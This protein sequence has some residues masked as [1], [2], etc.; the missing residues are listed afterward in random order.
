MAEKINWTGK[1]RDAILQEI[2][3]RG[4]DRFSTTRAIWYFCGDVLRLFPRTLRTYKALNALTVDMRQKQEIPWG[5]FSVVRG[6][7]G[8]SAGS[9]WSPSDFFNMYKRTFLN[10]KNRY[11][12]PKW[13][14]QDYHVEVWVEK[15]GLLPN[16]ERYIS[17]MDVQ[18]RALEGF[19]PWEFVHE[20]I[21][22]IKSYL[23]DRA[24]GAQIVIL[25]LGDNDPSG[26]DIDRQLQEVLDHFTLD[27]Q[28]ERIGLTPDIVDDF[29]LPTM[30]EPETVEKILKDPRLYSFRKML[31]DEYG[32]YDG[33]GEDRL[34]AKNILEDDAF[35]ELDAWNGTNPESMKTTLRDKIRTFYDETIWNDLEDERNKNSEE[36]NNLLNEAKKKLE[37]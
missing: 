17:D 29:S 19:P 12:M 21:P 13:L 8:V 36:L 23:D 30:P 4:D 1:V 15:K 25:Y 20:N 11:R 32:M 27:Y 7:N 28:F 24:E 5:Y 31:Q 35:T 34:H 37:E 6:V 33:V 10:A 2:E 22:D 9:N 18:V 3:K 14:N 16:I 26:W